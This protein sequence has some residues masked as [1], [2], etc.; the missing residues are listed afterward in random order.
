LQLDSEIELYRNIL[1]EAEQASGY[2]SPLVQMNENGTRQSRKR[3]RFNNYGMNT[4][5]GCSKN[6]NTNNKIQKGADDVKVKTPGL[7]RAAHNAQNDLLS[8][9]SDGSVSPENEMKDKEEDDS[10]FDEYQTPGNMEGASLQFSGL[11][12][13]KGMIEIQNMGETAIGLNG[14]NL[15]NKSGDAQYSLPKDMILKSKDKLRIYVGS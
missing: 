7:A 5:M 13:N 2:K 9:R 8:L 14:Y 11:D 12:L 4:P 1:N 3:K 15:S 10:E 6:M